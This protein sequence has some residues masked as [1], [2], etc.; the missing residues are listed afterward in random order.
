MHVVD[1]YCFLCVGYLIR[2][3]VTV[4]FT[5]TPGD[6]LNPQKQDCLTP[7]SFAAGYIT[8]NRRQNTPRAA[9]N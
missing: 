2:P 8:N 5:Q 6:I 3:T 7:P 4:T 9:F 1:V